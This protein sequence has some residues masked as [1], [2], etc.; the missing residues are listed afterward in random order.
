MKNNP[1]IHLRTQSSYS[2]SE[3]AIKIDKL[4]DL[5]K[6]ENMPA[7]ALTDNNNMFGALEF[8]IKCIQNGI[9]PIVGTS[10]NILSLNQSN[11]KFI[12]QATFIAKNEKG[13]HNLIKLSSKS[14]LNNIND[15]PGLELKDIYEYK[16]GLIIF[17]GGINTITC[18][19]NPI[20]SG[21]SP[22]WVFTLIF[23]PSPRRNNCRIKCIEIGC[24]STSS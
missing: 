19:C 2:L 16:D 24:I 12:N 6:S 5:T 18:F 3:S 8:S 4:I 20:V 1:F 22:P 21:S 23:Y 13:Y 10:I 7:V 15:F 11:N 9:Q 14:H 17:F